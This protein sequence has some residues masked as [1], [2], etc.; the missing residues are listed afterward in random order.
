MYTYEKALKIRQEH[1]KRI[2]VLDN[3]PHNVLLL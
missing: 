1:V 2:T 3:A